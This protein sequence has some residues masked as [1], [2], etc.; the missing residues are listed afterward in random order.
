MPKNETPA[1][2]YSCDLYHIMAEF[3][4]ALLGNR[5]C[6]A[7]AALGLDVPALLALAD[8]VIE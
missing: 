2:L 1:E 4:A 3:L 8:E 6:P 7:T 5:P